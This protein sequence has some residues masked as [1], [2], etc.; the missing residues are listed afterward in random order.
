MVFFP[1]KK[2][3]AQKKHFLTS[4]DVLSRLRSSIVNCCLAAN[5]VWLWPIFNSCNG[6]VK[7]NFNSAHYLT[8]TFHLRQ[9][10]SRNGIVK[11]NFNSAHYLTK[12]FN[13]VKSNIPQISFY[14]RI[15]HFTDQRYIFF[16]LTMMKFFFLF[17]GFVIYYNDT[18][19][20]IYHNPVGTL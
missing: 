16:Y 6:T 3:D 14:M 7:I 17:T 13:I 20:F 8:K 12:T 19:V 2:K 15:P 9:M 5:A 1:N 4:S 18:F 11:I 10:F